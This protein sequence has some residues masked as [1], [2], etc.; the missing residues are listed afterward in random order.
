MAA[1][2]ASLL[3]P[4]FVSSFVVR[5][6]RND[7]E[8]GQDGVRWKRMGRTQRIDFAGLVSA[9]VV[10]EEVPN[11]APRSHLAFHQRD[12]STLCLRVD[13]GPLFQALVARVEAARAYYEQLGES[14]DAPFRRSASDSLEEWAEALRG[15]LSNEASFR[16][17]TLRRDD[18]LHVV[19]DPRAHP[20]ARVGA[21]LALMQHGT[22][23]DR[24]RVRVAAEGTVH[25]KLRV[26]LTHALQGDVHEEEIEAAAREVR[27]SAALRG[28]TE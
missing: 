4:Y 28:E 14:A 7:V 6:F 23:T 13:H 15:A 27:A 22:P 5:A 8:V 2:F 25:P 21:A 26:A 1:T 17:A 20:E 3:L 9:E 16:Q 12:G 10:T 19:E 11:R 18:A 24:M